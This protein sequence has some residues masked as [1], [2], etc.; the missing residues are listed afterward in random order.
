MH[1]QSYYKCFPLLCESG[2]LA[3]MVSN[4][5]FEGSK[6]V[7]ET[8]KLVSSP[9]T[10]MW[11]LVVCVLFAGCLL[12]CLFFSLSYLP[13]RIDLGKAGSSASGFC[14][15]FRGLFVSS[16]NHSGNG[17]QLPALQ[18][19][20]SLSYTSTSLGAK[21]DV[22]VCVPFVTLN[23]GEKL[24]RRKLSCAHSLSELLASVV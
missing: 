8:S 16:Q 17:L 24:Q 2:L 12:L 23:H 11:I 10:I 4:I 1:H 6:S 21:N 20:A 3:T 13:F 9:K 18:G 15:L 14:L 7:K 22:I 19:L 5:W